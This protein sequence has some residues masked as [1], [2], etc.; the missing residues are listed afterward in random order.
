MSKT[1]T[2]FQPATLSHVTSTTL[3]F[4]LGRFSHDEAHINLAADRPD[5]D[6][7]PKPE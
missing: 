5:L 6:P 1:C 7:F 4:A 2:I 3:L